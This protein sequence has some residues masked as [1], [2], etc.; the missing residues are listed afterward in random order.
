MTNNEQIEKLIEAGDRAHLN[1]QCMADNDGICG[2]LCDEST[3]CD[4]TAIAVFNR[5][6]YDRDQQRDNADFFATAAN[7]RA[8]IK[9]MHEENKRLRDTLEYARIYVEKWCHYQGDSDS[10]F[11]QYL[12]P[13]DKALKGK[14]DD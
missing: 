1:G 7:S 6:D 14:D 5:Y 11:N 2:Y 12:S 8:A 10:L 9:A 4:M 3:Q 13:I